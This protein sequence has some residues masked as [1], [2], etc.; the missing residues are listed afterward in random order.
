MPG[1]IWTGPGSPSHNKAKYIK[2]RDF[3]NNW[4]SRDGKDVEE[5]GKELKVGTWKPKKSCRCTE[6]RRPW[7][8]GVRKCYCNRDLWKREKPAR[9]GLCTVSYHII[10]WRRTAIRR[11]HTLK[12]VVFI[13]WES[14]GPKP[15]WE[16]YPIEFGF[17]I[18]VPLPSYELVFCV[19]LRRRRLKPGIA[20]DRYEISIIFVIPLPTATTTMLYLIYTLFL[21]HWAH[22]KPH[23]PS[24]IHFL[25]CSPACSPL[26]QCSHWI[27]NR[28]I[29]PFIDA[30]SNSQG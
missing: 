11:L 12:F 2:W 20:K 22:R 29:D 18:C 8:L 17:Q 21:F 6:W 1:I 3:Y 30:S 28:S 4:R 24:A 25:V 19:D 7:G 16:Y 9:T 10:R 26:F 14:H 23:F 13:A 15:V 5:V 27:T